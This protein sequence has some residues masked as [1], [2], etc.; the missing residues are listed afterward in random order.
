M[1]FIIMVW[2]LKNILFSKWPLRFKD[3]PSELQI[4]K[5]C[6]NVSLQNMMKLG[7]KLQL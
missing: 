2:G 1:K 6:F 3:S 5:S 7:V 4:F